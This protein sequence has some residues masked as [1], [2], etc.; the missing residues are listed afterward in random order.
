MT[1]PL[2][3]LCAALG[4]VR[5]EEVLAAL[6]RLVRAA[7]AEGVVAGLPLV[8]LGLAALLTADRFRRV[9]AALGGGAVG[10]LLAWVASGWIAVHAGLAVGPAAA[11]AA[12]VL[13]TAC[14]L[15]PVLFPA[16]AGAAAGTLAGLRLPLGGN[17]PVGTAVAAAVGAALGLVGARSVAVILWCLAGGAV[18]GAGLLAL[19]GSGRLAADLAAR[20]MALVAF[21]LVVGIAGAA[22]QLSRPGPASFGPAPRRAPGSDEP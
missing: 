12:V 21:A 14:G 19:A 9:A 22:F 18:L 4:P 7:R 5:L 16:A 6:L 8:A 2:A 1:E 11:I 3:T 13:G 17:G 20:P 10:A 15:A